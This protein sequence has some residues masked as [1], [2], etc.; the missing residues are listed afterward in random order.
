MIKMATCFSPFRA[1]SRPYA[2]VKLP[3]TSPTS[4]PTQMKAQTIRIK[5]EIRFLYKKKQTSVWPDDGPIRAETCSHFYH[6]FN[7][8]NFKK[9]IVVSD[10]NIYIYYYF[11]IYTQWDGNH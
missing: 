1:I 10:G 9:I 5:Y 4:I 3:R 6:Y 8:L 7:C 2:H 11:C